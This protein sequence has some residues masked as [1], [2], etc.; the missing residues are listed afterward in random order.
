MPLKAWP[1]N[2]PT[3]SLRLTWPGWFRRRCARRHRFRRPVP[4]GFEAGAGQRVAGFAQQS[5]GG[6]A[7]GRVAVD[8][9]QVG[10]GQAEGGVNGFV[11][12]GG[13]LLVE[14]FQLRGFGTFLQLLRGTRRTLASAASS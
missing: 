3:S 8:Q 4:A 14:E 7:H 13:Q 12:F 1:S 10:Q 6:Q 2:S 11:L 9:L 5:H